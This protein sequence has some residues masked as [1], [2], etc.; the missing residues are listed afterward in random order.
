[1]IIGI[2]MVK[3]E[4]DIIGYTVQHLIQE[5]VSRFIIADNQSSDQ[6]RAVL[7]TFR[8]VTVVDDDDPAY[9][10]D[11]KMSAL[12]EQ[13]YEAGADWVL[14]FDADELW[15]SPHGRIADVLGG[16]KQ[17][18]VIKAWGY[19][20][21]PRRRSRNL[22]PWI[23]FP[24]RRAFTQQ[25]P[26]VAFRAEPGVHLHFGNHDVDHGGRRADTVLAYRHLQYRSFDQMRRKLRNGKAAYDATDLPYLYGTHWRDGGAKTDGELAA[27]WDALVD[28]E[29]VYD[30]APYRKPE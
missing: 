27:E 20:H 8:K 18:G 26:K 9:Y 30:P 28:E 17:F 22:N 25:L 14:P 4:A 23:A 6:T 19:D 10:Q 7:D 24:C 15:Y 2:A 21:I 5:G 11:R 1:M 29:G 3:D 13:A 12:A 16:C